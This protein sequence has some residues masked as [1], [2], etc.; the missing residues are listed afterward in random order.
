MTKRISFRVHGQV[1]GVSFRY[2]TRKK[3]NTYNLTGFVRNHPQGQVEG[4]AQGPDES[5]QMLVKDLESGP[6][7]ARVTKLEKEDIDVVEGEEGFVVRH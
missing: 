6:S 5:L 7:H 3:A 1:Q 4:E 2:F